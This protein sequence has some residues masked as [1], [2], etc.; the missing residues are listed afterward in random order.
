MLIVYRYALQTLWCMES[1]D[2]NTITDR[3]QQ[4]KDLTH[5]AKNIVC[6]AIG[7]S[8]IIEM[9]LDTKNELIVEMLGH[10]KKSSAELII[11]IE[12]MVALKM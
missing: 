1:D 7:A 4:L 6:N 9:E 5:T 11:V 2:T 12:K 10:I 3:K 8:E